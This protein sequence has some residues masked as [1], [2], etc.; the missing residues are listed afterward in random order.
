MAK[1]LLLRA[2]PTTAVATCRPRTTEHRFTSLHLLMAVWAVG[3]AVLAGSTPI[4]RYSG[5]PAARDPEQH[6]GPNADIY[7]G[8]VSFLLTL[9]STAALSLLHLLLLLPGRHLV[10]LSLVVRLRQPAACCA[11]E[12][13]SVQSEVH[14]LSLT[15]KP[16]I[17]SLKNRKSSTPCG[18]SSPFS[19]IMGRA[20]PSSSLGCLSGITSR[21]DAASGWLCLNL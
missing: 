4:P 2:W 11:G 6:H 19:F 9:V 10:L 17:Y 18:H 14:G 8:A 1:P 3:T 5:R 15:L 7:F 12:K 20:S 16:L 21:V 13:H